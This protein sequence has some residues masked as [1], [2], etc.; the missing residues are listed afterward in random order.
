MAGGRPLRL[1]WQD[2]DSVAALKQAF[3]QEQNRHVARRLQALW[4]LRQG[5]GIRETARTL[6]VG[7]RAIQRWLAW[8]R[9]GGLVAVRTPQVAG[10]GRAAL[11][12]AAQQTALVDDVASGTVHTAQDAVDWVAQEYGVR[13]RLGGMYSLL[14]RL[15][16]RPKVPRPANP[17]SSAAVQEAWKKGGSPQR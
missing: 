7:E 14:R 3:G 1:E 6:G 5:R 17:K 2:R 15:R 9:R 10:K 4:Q 16:C 13:Y 8:Y 12:S 11:L